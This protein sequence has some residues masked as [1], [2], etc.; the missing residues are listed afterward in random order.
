MKHGIPVSA[1]QCTMPRPSP[2]AR[3]TT[4]MGTYGRSLLPRT[5]SSFSA[6]INN[7]DDKP[8]DEPCETDR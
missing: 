8:S 7:A 4:S 5:A 3:P 1:H 6:C 2:S